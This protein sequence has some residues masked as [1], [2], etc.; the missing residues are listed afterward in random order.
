MDSKEDK[1]ELEPVVLG[2]SDGSIENSDGMC[3]FTCKLGGRPAWL[4]ETSKIPCYSTTLCQECGSEMLMLV[5][6]YVPLN[7]SPYDRA[8][9]IWSCNRRSCTGKPG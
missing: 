5:Q 6:T 7:D 2:Y 4:D 9:Y 8:I 3:P 1:R